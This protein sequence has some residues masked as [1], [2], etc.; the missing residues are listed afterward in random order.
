MKLTAF[1]ASLCLAL[2]LSAQTNLLKNSDFEQGENKGLPTY[3][4]R[5]ISGGST[6]FKD[7]KAGFRGS[8]CGHLVKV[9]DGTSH[10]SALHQSVPVT[11]S[12]EYLISG[13][14]KG[15]GFLF[16]YEYSKDNK[17]LR[18]GKGVRV[19]NTTDWTPVS[20]V[21]KTSP[22]TYICK[23]RFEIYGKEQDGDGWIDNVYFGPIPAKTPAPTEV[24]AQI[25]DNKNVKLTWKHSSPDEI[26]YYNIFRSRYPDLST[27]RE[28]S[29]ES[30]TME[31]IDKDIP[32]D[33]CHAYYAIVPMNKFH[34]TGEQSILCTVKVGTNTAK[35]YIWTTSSMDKVRRYQV[36]PKGGLKTIDLFMAQNE[37]ESAQI[38]VNAG[39]S[40]LKGL[41]VELAQITSIDGKEVSNDTLSKEILEVRYTM[42]KGPRV[43]ET[44]PGLLPDPLPPWRGTVDV[45]EEAN[46]SAW[47]L[48]K[49]SPSCPPGKYTCQATVKA[50]GRILAE[51]PIS[52][53]VLDFALPVTPSYM[54][55]FLI[56]GNH[57]AQAYG[58]KAGSPEYKKIYEKYYWFMADHRLLPSQLPVPLDS[59]EADRYLKDPRVNS[60]AITGAWLK[61]NEPELR[62]NADALRRRGKLGMGYVYCYDEP[63]EKQYPEV[64]ALADE[65][66]KIGKDI[67]VLLTEQPEPLLFGSIDIWCPVLDYSKWDT[68]AAERKAAGDRFWWYTCIWPP[69]PYPTYW[70]DD[71]GVAPR[72]I[73]WMQAQHNISG[74]LYWSVNVWHKTGKDKKIEKESTVWNDAEIYP[75][76]NGEG[77]LLYPG[78][79]VGVDGPVSSIRL[80]ILRDSYEDFEYLE[81]I[82]NKLA[83]APKA[84]EKLKALIS[85]VVTNIRDGWSKDYKV[86]LKQRRILAQEILR[87]NGK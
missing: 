76:G 50:E 42:V 66:H 44:V 79:K 58:V 69:P 67:P 60:V 46:Q 55:S 2:Q 63:T 52:I 86:L 7:D 87:L 38:C 78:N 39:S 1:A 4:E 27:S 6:A 45:P 22:D 13:L 23:I 56:W 16:Y 14:G 12:T 18:N 48:F 70:V 17:Y 81:I 34:Q 9:A 59:P 37:W 33:W 41:D 74:I 71:I 24:N 54:S 62:K 28:P 77:F 35:P 19:D 85:P 20:A 3:W 26:A 83:G 47:L 61:V 29:G 21:I 75:R 5:N 64:K 30:Y 73:A 82:R 57:L 84:D 80:E 36:P 32:K 11:P 43:K 25:V 40:I 65:I 53:E 49:A 51:I 72:T 31:W 10:V 8:A 68:V 15:K